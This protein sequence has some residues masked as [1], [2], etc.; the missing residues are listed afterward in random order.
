MSRERG[1][2]LCGGVNSSFASRGLLLRHEATWSFISHVLS[3]FTH[4]RQ[5]PIHH[6]D[7]R[8]HPAE[9]D[10]GQRHHRAHHRG[11]HLLHD[12]VPLIRCGR[13]VLAMDREGAGWFLR[14]WWWCLRWRIESCVKKKKKKLASESSK[15]C[16]K[17][18]SAVAF[19]FIFLV[20]FARVL[21]LG[22]VRSERIDRQF[23]FG[24][25]NGC[26]RAARCASTCVVVCWS[27]GR[28][29]AASQ[30]AWLAV[31]RGA[32]HV[33]GRGGIW[34]VLDRS[35]SL[36]T[37]RRS[38]TAFLAS[39]SSLTHTGQAGLPLR[40]PPPASMTNYYGR[41]SYWDDRYTK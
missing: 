5:P 22:R 4:T 19:S 6:A 1:I 20:C 27:I 37:P 13:G 31:A 40:T 12:M 14:W 30:D 3:P 17:M 32:G 24:D 34:L 18:S 11:L 10:A 41:A 38:S 21:V 26:A 36:I 7:R 8:R 33:L 35:I 39:S 2:D 28:R 16:E 15:H 9:K 25:R 23:R 29:P